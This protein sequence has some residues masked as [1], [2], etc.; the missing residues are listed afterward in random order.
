MQC[1]TS[2]ELIR[3]F[4]SSASIIEESL[5]QSRRTLAAQNEECSHKG[6]MKFWIE[7]NC[8]FHRNLLNKYTEK[9]IG[10]DFQNNKN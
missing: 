1:R 10:D 5:E 4:G 3:A 2:N 7:C 6:K 8:I 9:H